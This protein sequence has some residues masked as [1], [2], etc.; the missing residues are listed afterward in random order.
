MLGWNF[1]VEL[2]D[3]ILGHNVKYRGPMSR[4]PNLVCKARLSREGGTPKR[5]EI[6]L[7]R[8]VKVDE[9]A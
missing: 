4:M 5:P 1:E 3:L 9:I 7:L 2:V 8:G 6:W